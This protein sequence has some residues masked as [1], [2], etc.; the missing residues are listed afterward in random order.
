MILIFQIA[1]GIL[2]ALLLLAVLAS[3]IPDHKYVDQAHKR[4]V[5]QQRAEAKRDRDIRAYIL[6]NGK[7]PRN[8]PVSKIN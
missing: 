1:A 2:L 8:L 6:G 3:L 7:R 5:K 4:L